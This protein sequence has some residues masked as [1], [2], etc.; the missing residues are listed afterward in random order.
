[1]PDFR[2]RLATTPEDRAAVYRLR[3]ELYVEAQGL[4][5]EI[6]DHER[7][8]FCDEL[9]EAALVW[10]AELDGRAVGTIRLV[11]GEHFDRELREAFD[12]EIFSAVVADQRIAE[13]SR[14]LVAPE[15]RAGRLTIMLV[16]A[17]FQV[18][19]ERGLE[20]VLA[21]CEPHLINTWHRLGFRPYGLREHPVNGT[22]VRIALVVGDY[23]HARRIRSPVA[24][25][26]RKHDVDD[27]TVSRLRELV[28]RG[29]QVISEVDTHSRYWAAI[30]MSVARGE[31]AERL[32]ELTDE[33]LETLLDNGH[34]L[35]CAPG[36]ML[37]RKGH[38]SRTLYVLLAGSLV[39]RDEGTTI[40]EVRD[41]GE[42]VGEIAFFTEGERMSD[43]LAGRDG[44]RV[45]ALSERS[46]SAMVDAHGTAAAKLLLSVTRSVC[47]KLR[48][49]A[50]H[51]SDMLTLSGSEPE[52]Q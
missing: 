1:M 48:Q 47:Q 31:L 46:L 4:F 3:Y 5:Q 43:V 21:E 20:V 30:E 2:I 42:L 17:A 9:D 37:I 16:F 26:V 25:V 44:A 29:Q 24:S 41:P 8:W 18:A 23:E 40:V 34:A 11:L 28:L 49:R 38:V 35:D 32:G 45:L 14:M 12:V 33:E 36:A 50:R 39:V 51:P 15:H 27:P 13:A 22:L 6:A 7:R 19:I 52:S 10:L